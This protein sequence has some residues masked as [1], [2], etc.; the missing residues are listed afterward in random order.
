MMRAVAWA[1]D[2]QPIGCDW[3]MTH[4]TWDRQIAMIAPHAKSLA[5]FYEQSGPLVTGDD[6]RAHRWHFTFAD[7]VPEDICE[8]T[9]TQIVNE[10]QAGFFAEGVGTD[11]NRFRADPPSSP[12]QDPGRGSCHGLLRPGGHPDHPRSGDVEAVEVY[13]LV[14]GGNGAVGEHPWSFCSVFATSC[15]DE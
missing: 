4:L 2:P 10:A 9:M 13:G 14:P 15:T 8:F 7:S 12:Q 1:S 3:F 11:Q 5:E 6:D